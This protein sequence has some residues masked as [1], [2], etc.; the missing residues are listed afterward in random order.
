MKALRS[1]LSSVVYH[2]T[3]LLDRKQK[4]TRMLCYHRVNDSEK[5]Y[6]TVS[7]RHFR[8]QMKFLFNEGY[9]TISLSSLLAGEGNGRN[10]VITFDDGFR[11]NFECAYPILKEFGFRATIFCVADRM[12]TEGYLTRQDIREMRASGFEFGSHTISHPHLLRLK[13]D[14]K[15]QEI[16]GSKKMLED[17]TQNRV[18]FFC[19]PYGEYDKES[20]ALVKKVGYLGACSNNPGANDGKMDHYLLKRTEVSPDDS[21]ND[22][23]KKMAGAFDLLHRGLHWVRRRP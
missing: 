15:W 19:Y 16:F 18:D 14:K 9:Q 7:T 21:L 12:N 5:N 13:A 20:V 4:G 3:R 11:D 6:L 17:L 2:G 22:F 8:D 10:I 23:K 1:S